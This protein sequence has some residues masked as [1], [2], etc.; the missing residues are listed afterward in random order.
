MI[1]WNVMLC[2]I[3]PKY[4]YFNCILKANLRIKWKAPLKLC[5]AHSVPQYREKGKEMYSKLGVIRNPTVTLTSKFL[6]P[7]EV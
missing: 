5:F 2:K 1:I 4:C 3:K 6:F 7:M